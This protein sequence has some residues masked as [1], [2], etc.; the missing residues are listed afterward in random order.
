L[1]QAGTLG[2]K[3]VLAVLAT[4]WS[5]S[6]MLFFKSYRH[7]GTICINAEEDYAC[8]ACNI[9]GRG[10]VCCFLGW[11]CVEKDVDIRLGGGTMHGNPPLNKMLQCCRELAVVAV[12]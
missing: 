7:Q 2:E 9:S 12:F 11:P 8:S 5:R 4:L 1:Y 6:S 3:R 10:Q